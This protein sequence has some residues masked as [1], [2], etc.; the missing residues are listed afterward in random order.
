[1]PDSA[2]T[3][4]PHLDPAAFETLGRDLLRWL[5]NHLESS[6]SRPVAAPVA[7]G[8]IHRRFPVSP[9]EHGSSLA[10]LPRELDDLIVPGLTGWQSPNW[11]AYFPCNHS[12]PS[13][14]GELLSAEG[15]EAALRS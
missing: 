11:F 10:D 14:L 2:S 8:E 15:E 3:T 9:P 12:Y 13:I 6:D 7:P 1:M 4:S 5:T